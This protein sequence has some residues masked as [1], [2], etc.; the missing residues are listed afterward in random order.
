VKNLPPKILT[1]EVP[2]EEFPWDRLQLSSKVTD[3]K[4]K[5]LK[6]SDTEQNKT[7][8]FAFVDTRGPANVIF[9][10]IVPEYQKIFQ[11]S[12]ITMEISK[13]LL[14]KKRSYSL[15]I[16]L[17]NFYAATSGAIINAT[18]ISNLKQIQIEKENI[19]NK[20][21]VATGDEIFK[22]LLELKL[23]SLEQYITLTRLQAQ[24][25]YNL[26]RWISIA[27][28]ILLAVGII[29]SISGNILGMKILDG[30]YLA[31]IAGIISEFISGIFFVFY[32]K[33]LQQINLFHNKLIESQNIAISLVTTDKI[34]NSTKRDDCKVE[35]AKMLIITKKESDD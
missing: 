4:F 28:F 30:A 26:V 3:E 12:D 23:N 9:T 19:T 21:K 15:P 33:T 20:L 25:T 13:F 22:N 18:A 35:L 16:H 17:E 29:L 34:E 11:I 32:N 8:G 27:G 10:D 7:V 31:A 14:D 24:Q 1:S 5:L 6:F 2:S